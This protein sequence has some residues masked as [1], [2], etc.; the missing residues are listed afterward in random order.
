MPG[1]TSLMEHKGKEKSMNVLS[2]NRQALSLSP[3]TCSALVPSHEVSPD[4]NS[5]HGQS[6]D[7]GGWDRGESLKHQAWPEACP[8]G[9]SS[10]DRPN[11]DYPNP[12]YSYVQSD[13][14]AHVL[15]FSGTPE[16][17]GQGGRLMLHVFPVWKLVI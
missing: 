8:T 7:G 13:T 17:F 16:D 6:V 2:D 9:P 3:G 15:D 14:N 12:F 11:S 4:P 5:V 1:R 10:P